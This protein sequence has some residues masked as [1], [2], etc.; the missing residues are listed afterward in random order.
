MEDRPVLGDGPRPG[1][2]DVGR[3]VRLSRAV[4]TLAA[5]GAAAVRGVG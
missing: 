2:T 1:A 4:W 5:A 3:A